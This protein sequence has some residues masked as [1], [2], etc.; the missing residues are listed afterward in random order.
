MTIHKSAH[1]AAEVVP[2]EYHNS[3]A[4]EYARYRAGRIIIEKLP[5]HPDRVGRDPAYNCCTMSTLAGV[6]SGV[7][8]KPDGDQ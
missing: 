6:A 2:G 5:Y 7:P 3:D 8:R 1:E 4:E